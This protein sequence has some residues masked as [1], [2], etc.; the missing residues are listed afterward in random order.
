MQAFPILSLEFL[1]RLQPDLEMLADTPAIEIGGHAGELYFTM[2]GL[3]RDA[4]EGAIR[5]AEAKSVGG[6]CCGLHVERDSA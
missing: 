1:Q 2:E 3:I 6:D 5:H 4:Q